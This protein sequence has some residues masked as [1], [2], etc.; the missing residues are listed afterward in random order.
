MPATGLSQGK[1]I[2]CMKTISIITTTIVFFLAMTVITGFV[3]P[4]IVTGFA[5]VAFPF[6]AN[7]SMIKTGDTLRGSRLLVQDFSS[8]EF[9]HGRPSAVS[10]G[11]VPSG[12]SNLSPVGQKL[13]D[14]VAVRQTELKIYG[15]IAIPSDLLYASAS[16]LDPDISIDAALIQVDRIAS[17]RGFD[18]S[19]KSALIEYVKNNPEKRDIFPA[20]AR[21]NIMDLNAK[22]VAN[23]QFALGAQ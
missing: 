8:D 17:A 15:D 7:G 11:T 18:V 2:G 4:L 3:Y 5:Q 14:A 19:Q 9:F 1:G 10:Y 21:V 20:Q 23:T 6:Q 12:A 13:T 22:L 16:G